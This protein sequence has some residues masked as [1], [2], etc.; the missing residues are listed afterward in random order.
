MTVSDTPPWLQTVT[1]KR[2][3]RDDA[4]QAFIEMHKAPSEYEVRISLFPPR[5]CK[6]T[7]P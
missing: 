3:I 1:K 6:L 5:T 7:T 2:Q 4:I